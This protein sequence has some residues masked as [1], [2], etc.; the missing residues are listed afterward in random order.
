MYLCTRLD[1]VIS[2][3]TKRAEFRPVSSL[4]SCL[5][6]DV[7][8]SPLHSGCLDFCFIKTCQFHCLRSNVYTNICHVQDFPQLLR[9]EC[10]LQPHV[11]VRKHMLQ[12]ASTAILAIA[13]GLSDWDRTFKAMSQTQHASL[14]RHQCAW[15]IKTFCR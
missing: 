5:P 9:R 3:I 13:A 10:C 11:A 15:N 2:V 12:F 8:D 1:E 4:L 14:T 7:V 6:Q